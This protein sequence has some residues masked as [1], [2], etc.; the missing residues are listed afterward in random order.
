MR[1]FILCCAS[2][3]TML[4][5]LAAPAKACSCIVP[6]PPCQAYGKSS[7]VFSGQ[8]LEIV[9]FEAGGYP[10]KLVRF[11]VSEAFRGMSGSAAEI[12]TGNGGG[13]CGYPFRVGESYLVYAYRAPQDNRLYAGICSRT[14]PLSEASEDLEYIRGLSKAES[15]GQIFGSV[16]RFRRVNADVSHQPLGPMEGVR[17]T[18]EGGG[19]RLVAVTDG[20]GSYRAAGLRP[21]GYLVRIKAPDGLY[22]SDAQ[23]KVEITDKGCAVVDFTFQPN[24]SLSGQVFDEDSA[25]APKILVDLIP[26]DEINERYQRYILFVHTDDEGRFAFRTIPSGTYYLG[27]RLNRIT[28]PTFPYPGRFIRGP[29]ILRKPS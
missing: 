28:T 16:K 27:I 5:L 9:P 2:L 1:I 26:S 23:H 25:P 15:G 29:R 21:G 19:K 20:K 14:G 24:T 10:Q 6:G 4:L 3:I 18:I 11:S 13:D 17:V 7:A 12:A 22:P 8:V